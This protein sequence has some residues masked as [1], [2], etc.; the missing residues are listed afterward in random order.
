MA[1]VNVS[2]IKTTE[3]ALII[4]GG[5]CFIM[6]YTFT[7]SVVLPGPPTK[8]VT[9]KSSIESVNAII[10]PAAIPGPSRG[11]IILRKILILLIINKINTS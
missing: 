3:S 11:S 6:L 2:A 4:A 10:A 8:N 7:G 1:T 5:P 9:T